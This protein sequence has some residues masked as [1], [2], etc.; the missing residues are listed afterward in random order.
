MSQTTKSDEEGELNG[1]LCI[2]SI[3]ALKDSGN[4]KVGV[5]CVRRRM[6]E[7]KEDGAQ[8][9][10]STFEFDDNEHFMDLNNLVTRLD[11]SNVVV[12]TKALSDEKFAIASECPSRS[13]QRRD[14]ELKQFKREREDI[15]TEL[16]RLLGVDTL[17]HHHSI[18]DRGVVLN[19]LGALLNEIRRVLREQAAQ[20]SFELVECNLDMYMR[21]DRSAVYALNLFPDPFE[22]GGNKYS[23]LIGVL[24]HCVTAGMGSRLLRRWLRQPLRDLKKIQERQSLVEIFVNNDILRQSL[25]EGPLRGVLDIPKTLRKL[26]A[27]TQKK[28]KKLDS[29]AKLKELYLI[30]R[31]AFELPDIVRTLESLE[32]KE[33]HELYVTRLL[34]PLRKI[35]TDLKGLM[36]LCEHVIDLKR[37]EM[38]PAEYVVDPYNCAEVLQTE[39]DEMSLSDIANEREEVL[40][41][42]EKIYSEICK[43]WGSNLDLKFENDRTSGYCMRHAKKNQKLVQSCAKKNGI[44]LT[45]I[46]I[47]NRGVYV[48]TDD[49]TRLSRQMDELTR[50]YQNAQRKVV[51]EAIGVALTYAPVLEAVS[52][53][54]SELDVFLS[55]AKVATHSPG[56]TYVLWTPRSLET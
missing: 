28:G 23:S 18:L 50:T 9:T 37:A 14:V 51:D 11:P 34:Q 39:E 38:L 35:S 16:K 47:V 13:G 6:R 56:G 5:S 24:D 3:F 4:R 8:F 40:E 55:L 30:Y 44:C 36:D 32:D 31:M 20:G 42:I 27:S 25:Q 43:G 45:V 21:L 26:H 7:S 46:K 29:S 15:S 33:T 22:K 53:I 19:S 52:T 10:I 2:V 1:E 17:I 54:L 49:M 12:H 48:R 41:N